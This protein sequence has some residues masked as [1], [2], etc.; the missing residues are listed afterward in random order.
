MIPT[1]KAAGKPSNVTS[2]SSRTP[3]NKT[4]KG[5]TKVSRKTIPKAVPEV[6]PKPLREPTLE[7]MRTSLPESSRGGGTATPIQEIGASER[8][9]DFEHNNSEKLEKP[10]V[11]NERLLGDSIRA[12]S[13]DLRGSRPRFKTVAWKKSKLLIVGSA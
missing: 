11:P 1:G 9:S 13:E 7:S 10:W 6:M 12:G 4:K 2:K 8:R 5:T 3:T